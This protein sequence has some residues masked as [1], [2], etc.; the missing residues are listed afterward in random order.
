MLVRQR[1]L[2]DL[3]EDVRDSLVRLLTKAE[4]KYL[5]RGGINVAY[6]N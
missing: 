6:A 2:A 1:D 4:L 3:S 5:E